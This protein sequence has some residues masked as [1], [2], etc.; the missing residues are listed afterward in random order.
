MT[1]LTSLYRDINLLLDMVEARMK[2]FKDLYEKKAKAK[3]SVQKSNEAK[4]TVSD[5]EEA[6]GKK[7]RKGVV[8]EIT[9]SARYLMLPSGNIL[10]FN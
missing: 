1:T 6:T 9:G 8:R 3:A 7:E 5:D 4:D 2:Q 10:S